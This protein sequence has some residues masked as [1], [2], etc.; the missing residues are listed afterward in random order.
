MMT[1]AELIKWIREH[2]AEKMDI[3]IDIRYANC[4]MTEVK[5]I[6]QVGETFVL[7]R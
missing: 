1:G 4:F 5:I 6:Q 7:L 3:L 2:H